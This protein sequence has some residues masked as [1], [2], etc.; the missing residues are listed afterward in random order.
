MIH[1]SVAHTFYRGR[2]THL[3][4]KSIKYVKSVVITTAQVLQDG[5]AKHVCN[6]SV[7]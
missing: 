2:Y 5:N 1:N 3:M 4:C 6:Q 7:T